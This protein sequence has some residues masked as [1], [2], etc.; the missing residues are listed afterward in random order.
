MP[1]WI[2]DYDKL[3]LLYSLPAAN[4]ELLQHSPESALWKGLLCLNDLLN[5]IQTLFLYKHKTY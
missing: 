4:A 2:Q 3:L 5:I 1:V